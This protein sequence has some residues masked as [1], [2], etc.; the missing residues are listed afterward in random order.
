[1]EHA[2]DAVAS[3]GARRSRRCRPLARPDVERWRGGPRALGSLRALPARGGGRRPRGENANR[4]RRALRRHAW[5][6]NDGAPLRRGGGRAVDHGWG[7]RGARY[8]A[9]PRRGQ[10]RGVSLR[11]QLV[12]RELRFEVLM[13][14]LRIL[15]RAV[16]ST[17]LLGAWL[18]FTV[19]VAACESH[20]SGDF[21][22]LPCDEDGNCVRGYEC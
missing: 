4:L 7:A 15:S 6:A 16:F 5:A 1:S 18:G 20:L 14:T 9:H 3:H 13:G 11:R 21:S 19:A 22:G 17:R 12:F 8:P 2:T 10:P